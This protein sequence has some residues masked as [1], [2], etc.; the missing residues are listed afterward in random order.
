MKSAVTLAAI[1]NA[2]YTSG[3]SGI[4]CASATFCHRSV[5]DGLTFAAD[6]YMPKTLNARDVVVPFE[7]D[8]DMTKRACCCSAATSNAC[9]TAIC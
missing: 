6:V 9:S 7:R 1:T 4:C 8:L 3:V 2:L 5:E